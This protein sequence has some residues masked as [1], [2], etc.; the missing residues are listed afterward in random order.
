MLIE[1]LHVGP[2]PPAVLGRCG[3]FARKADRIVTPWHWEQDGFKADVAGPVGAKVVHI[4]ESLA[5]MEA[6]VA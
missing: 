3:T 2:G 4:P 5:T 1:P 6:Q